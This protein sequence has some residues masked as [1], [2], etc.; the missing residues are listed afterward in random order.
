MNKRFVC[1]SLFVCAVLLSCLGCGEKE[2]APEGTL[3]FCVLKY[4]I[5]DQPIA[6]WASKI[7]PV[8]KKRKIAVF[9]FKVTSPDLVEH[10]QI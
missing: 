8:I 2:E 9:V 3:W 5:S 6:A 10:G 7:K 4:K 1:L